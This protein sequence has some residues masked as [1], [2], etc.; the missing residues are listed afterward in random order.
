MMKQPAKANKL[1]LDAGAKDA[2]DFA[3]HLTKSARYQEKLLLEI[4]Q[5]NA[6]TQIGQRLDF[7]TIQS[8]DQFKKQ[9]PITENWAALQADIMQI[10]AGQSDVLFSGQPLFFEETSGSFGQAKAIPY[11]A[12][13][14]AGFQRAFNSWL[15]NLNKQQPKIFQGA[16][17]WSLSPPIKAKRTT[18]SGIPVGAP[19]DAS[20]FSVKQQQLLADILVAPD[21]QTNQLNARVFYISTW[22]ALLRAPSITFFSIWSPVFLLQLHSF[23]IE[24]FEA[25]LD[26]VADSKPASDKLRSARAANFSWAVLFPELQ[27]VSCWDQ[28]QAAVWLPQLREVIGTIPI[29]GKGLLSTEG[30]TTIPYGHNQH[31]LA[32]TSHFF[33]FRDWSTKEVMCADKLKID[34]LYEVILT[35]Q[36]G[37]YRYATG[38]VV[39]CTSYVG[40]TPGLR[41][42]GRGQETSDLVG[43]KL[44][45]LSLP[46]FFKAILETHQIDAAALYLCSNTK[47]KAGYC[48]VASG[49]SEQEA[50]TLTTA[51][52][53]LLCQNP[54]YEQALKLGQLAPLTYRV[55]DIDFTQR[56][57]RLYQKYKQIADGDIKLPLLYT[58]TF[59]KPIFEN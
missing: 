14:L 4:M 6:K 48:L 56:L 33:E 9:V 51:L 29:Q 38:D 35:T 21:I 19:S 26:A 41:F 32:F 3:R 53:A 2:Q 25:V 28:G 47:P 39:V 12:P 44:S 59:L 23:L 31:L 16:S 11:N 5:V 1:F 8:I 15:H 42:L 46:A 27:L 37:L 30:V 36:G 7:A 17:Y 10:E 54:Y 22:A 58:E 40:Q 57:F 49:V 55:T 43:E 24:N 50:E 45:A 20:Y 13:L 52:E 18:T 34:G